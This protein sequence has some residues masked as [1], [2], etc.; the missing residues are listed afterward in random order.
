[1]TKAAKVGARLAYR[2]FPAECLSITNGSKQA[3]TFARIAEVWFRLAEEKTA[4]DGDDKRKRMT[5]RWK[6]LAGPQESQSRQSLTEARLL[7]GRKRPRARERR[8]ALPVAAA[9]TGRSRRAVRGLPL[10]QRP[11]DCVSNR[12]GSRARW[13]HVHPLPREER[14]TYSHDARRQASC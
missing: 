7:L 10:C 3:A 14:V 11:N 8:G 2:R 13:R 4:E 6:G 5:Q 9:R 1:M 12:R